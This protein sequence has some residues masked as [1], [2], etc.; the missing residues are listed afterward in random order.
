MGERA[1]SKQRT[2]Q[3][4]ANA[5]LRM[6]T[7]SG[8]DAVTMAEVAS[9]AGVSRRTAFRYFA[10]KND[11]VM[12]HPT[13]WRRVF[14]ASIDTHRA[15]PLSQRIRAASH[16]VANH[17]ESN[18]LAVKQLVALAFAH[19]ALSARY[20]ANTQL[21]VERLADEIERDSSPGHG[22]AAKARMLAAAI[23]GII[24][25]VCELW[26][27]DDQPMGPLLDSGLDLV[28]QP[29][30]AIETEKEASSP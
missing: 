9:A 1:Q 21:W 8:Y 19:P 5:A 27:R 17:I 13:A 15:L 28:S 6:F 30:R 4:L 22:S 26:A 10:S 11:L 25:C 12:E 24:N 2:R 29:L 3:A 7:K 20:A 18:S 23:V 14:D 16:D